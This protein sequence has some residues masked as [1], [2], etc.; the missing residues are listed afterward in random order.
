MRKSDGRKIPVG[1]EVYSIT[2]S[3]SSLLSFVCLYNNKLLGTGDIAQRLRAMTALPE[4]LSSIP[5]NHM[6]VHSHL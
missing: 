6:V 2:S 5:S 3:L 1:S 4:V